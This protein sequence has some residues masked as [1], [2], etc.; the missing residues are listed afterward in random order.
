MSGMPP[1]TTP[2]P[3][4]RANSG[5]CAI[6]HRQRFGRRRIGGLTMPPVHRFSPEKRLDRAIQ[7][8]ADS[9]RFYAYPAC[10]K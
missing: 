1:L 6:A 10:L 3:T 2:N 5:V 9:D 4:R 8:R 7:I